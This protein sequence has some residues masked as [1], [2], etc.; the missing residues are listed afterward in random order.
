MSRTA[1]PISELVGAVLSA[2]LTVPVTW[3]LVQNVVELSM[4]IEKPVIAAAVMGETPMLPV[5]FEMGVVEIP[6]F[7]RITKFAALPRS[8]FR[9]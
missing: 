7:V 6:V 8:T 5:I 1:V 9:E 4:V 2:A 3:L